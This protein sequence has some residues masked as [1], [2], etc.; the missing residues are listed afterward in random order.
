MNQQTITKV[1]LSGLHC[2]ACQ[3]LTSRMISKINGVSAVDVDLNK[4]AATVTADRPLTLD[5]IQKALEGSNYVAESIE[6]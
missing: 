6:Q 5:E 2:Q 4:S 3:K 1:K